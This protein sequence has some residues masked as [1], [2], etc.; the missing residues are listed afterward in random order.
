MGSGYQTHATEFPPQLD[1]TEIETRCARE[2]FTWGPQALWLLCGLI[3]FFYFVVRDVPQVA[4]NTALIGLGVTVLAALGVRY[5]LRRRKR[6]IALYPRGERIGLYSGGVFQYSF[7]PAEMVWVR[8]DFFA[9]AMTVLK[10]LLPM[11]LV[12]ATA[13][14]VMFVSLKDAGPHAWQDSAILA[15][16]LLFAIFGFA[17][18]FRSRLILA[19][20]WLPNGKGKADRPAHFHTSELKKLKKGELV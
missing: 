17:A 9:R 4:R 16:C 6:R 2:S 3:W 10:A 12:A 15:Y 1:Q 19:F 11:L 8:L 18:I 5:E 14:V 7:T 20:F 13:G